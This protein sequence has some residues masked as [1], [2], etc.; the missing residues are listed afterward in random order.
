MEL[1]TVSARPVKIPSAAGAPV[2][3]GLIHWVL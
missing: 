2:A 1:V 3:G